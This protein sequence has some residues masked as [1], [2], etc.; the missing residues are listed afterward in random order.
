M[1]W[2]LALVSGV[3]ST[4]LGSTTSARPPV[5]VK[6]VAAPAAPPDDL[7]SPA[8]EVVVDVPPVDLPAIPDF[9]DAPPALLPMPR[10]SAPPPARP[11]TARARSLS[12]DALNLCHAALGERRF[13]AALTACRA[14]TV[15]WGGNHLAWYASANAEAATHGWSAARD[16]VAR[17]VE[18]RPDIA[19][20]QL[21]YGA[22]LYRAASERAR[23]DDDPPRRFSAARVALTRALAIAPALWR[24]HYYLG[25]IALDRHAER[26]AAEHFTAALRANPSHRESYVALSEL[27]RAGGHGSQALAV[28]TIGTQRVPDAA[29]LW[30]EVAMAYDAL[31][32]GSAAINALGRAIALSPDDVLLKLERGRLLFQRGDLGAARRDLEAA[33]RVADPAV[34]AVAARARQL[35]AE[36]EDGKLVGGTARRC[37]ASRGCTSSVIPHARGRGSAD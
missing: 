31:D 6:P 33:A 27:Y 22:A 34:A 5:H 4:A 17:A 26:D 21:L 2:A 29:T 23:S 8:L 7:P 11:V 24:A 9:G 28:A 12:I 3:A 18:L 20:Y 19:M 10:A 25:C 16:A 14:A 36:L 32:A 13:A 15:A 1:A 35:L 37:R 30:F